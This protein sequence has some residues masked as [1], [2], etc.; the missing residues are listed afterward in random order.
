[1]GEQPEEERYCDGRTN[2]ALD[3]VGFEAGENRV[4]GRLGRVAEVLG[5]L[6]AQIGERAE[7]SQLGQDDFQ[8]Q[9][10]ASARGV[11]QRLDV[12]LVQLLQILRQIR[13][14]EL[15]PVLF[16]L[17]GPD[18]RHDR[19]AGLRTGS[20]PVL[21][22]VA[23]FEDGGEFAQDRTHGRT[24]LL[25]ATRGLDGR[26]GHVAGLSIRLKQ[27]RTILGVRPEAGDDLDAGGQQARQPV[28]VGQA[29]LQLVERIDDDDRVA[30]GAQLGELLTPHLPNL[31]GILRDLERDF[32]RRL[33]AVGALCGPRGRVGE[34]VRDLVQF[35]QQVTQQAMDS[36]RA[37][38]RADEAA[39]DGRL[40]V[41]LCPQSVVLDPVGQ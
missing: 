6:V 7:H 8:I 29:G 32:L 27:A 41:A 33:T 24:P 38:A 12:L 18:R 34:L 10:V 39:M 22:L 28:H 40:C 25:L 21:L 36:G 4:E 2:V 1:M 13:A 31:V 23:R 15:A 5:D 26:H 35:P 16:V 37:V 19:V 9:G 14:H 17:E 3:G 20:D 11:D 30:F